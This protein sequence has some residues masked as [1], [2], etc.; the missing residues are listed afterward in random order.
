MSMSSDDNISAK[1]FQK[2]TRY[3][4]LEIE[5]AKMCKIKTKTIPV[6]VG[7]TDMIRKGTQKYVN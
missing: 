1:E 5:I 7:A 3:K 6:L 2:L 4:D